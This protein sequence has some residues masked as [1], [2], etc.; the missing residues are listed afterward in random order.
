M[1][2][3]TAVNHFTKTKPPQRQ[4]ICIYLTIFNDF[5]S[6]IL[7]SYKTNDNIIKILREKNIQEHIA[8]TCGA[9]YVYIINTKYTI[10]VYRSPIF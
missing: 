8:L 3:I 10:R 6:G 4:F 1:R 7:I 2:F 5:F 9:V